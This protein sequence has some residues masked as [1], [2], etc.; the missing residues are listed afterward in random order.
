M[1]TELWLLED[2]SIKKLIIESI[3]NCNKRQA[4]SR[5]QSKLCTM[6]LMNKELGVA[7]C[8]ITE[9]CKASVSRWEPNLVDLMYLSRGLLRAWAQLQKGK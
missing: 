7:S 1:K 2:E 5:L 6:V 4:I 8:P 3:D 9:Y